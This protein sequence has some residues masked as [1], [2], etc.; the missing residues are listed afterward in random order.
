MEFPPLG[1]RSIIYLSR[2][3]IGLRPFKKGDGLDMR[4]LGKKVHGLHAREAVA[5]FAEVARV[6]A[7]RVWIAGNVHN[8]HDGMMRYAL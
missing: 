4:R 7:Q 6:A 1:I 5:V 2:P 8:L 3:E